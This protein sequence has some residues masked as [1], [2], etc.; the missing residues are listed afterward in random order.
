MYMHSLQHNS[1]QQVIY[2]CHKEA[3]LIYSLFFLFIYFSNEHLRLLMYHMHTNKFKWFIS[4]LMLI[5][6]FLS[7]I[8]TFCE[9][10]H[11]TLMS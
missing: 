7:I 6:L 4:A 1:P 9:L 5:W 10:S 3:V 2:L 11:Q 8:S